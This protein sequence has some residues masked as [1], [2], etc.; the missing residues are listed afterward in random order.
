MLDRLRY[1]G[2]IYR[3]RKKVKDSREASR[4]MR[5]W[6]TA[7][8]DTPVMPPDELRSAYWIRDRAEEAHI[9]ELRQVRPKEGP[10]RIGAA[11]KA[12]DADTVAGYEQRS[13]RSVRKLQRHTMSLT[14]P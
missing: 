5:W 14:P 3:G 6:F 1:Y 13:R 10:K 11:W 9:R 4:Y 8:E 7:L 12:L 2:Q